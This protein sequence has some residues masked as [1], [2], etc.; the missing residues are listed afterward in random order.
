MHLSVQLDVSASRK[1]VICSN[2]NVG[3]FEYDL[4]DLE[5]MCNM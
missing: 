2:I 1:L 5:M 4:K 3:K